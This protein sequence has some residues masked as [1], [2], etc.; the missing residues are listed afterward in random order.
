M[1]ILKNI[2]FPYSF[3]D[4]PV[5]YI[6]LPSISHE[7]QLQSLLTIPFSISTQSTNYTI[8]WKNPIRSFRCIHIFPKLWLFVV[9][10]RKY[11][12]WAIF[13]VLIIITRVNMITRR[14][15]TFCI[16]RPSKFSSMGSPS[17]I[18]FWSIKYMLAC[19]GWHFQTL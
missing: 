3:V 13:D 7:R 16:S 5:F 2:G 11:E 17:R 1:S 15:I 10:S 14:M 6:F 9:I 19:Q 4:S 18:M 8:F 12:K